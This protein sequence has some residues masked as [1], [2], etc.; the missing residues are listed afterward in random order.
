MQLSSALPNPNPKIQKN[1][2][3]IKFLL[4]PDIEL[5]VSNI[6]KILMFS[7][8]KTFLILPAMEPCTFQSKLEK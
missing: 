4:F 6:K 5:S 8:K 2:T 1:S 7:R 3:Q